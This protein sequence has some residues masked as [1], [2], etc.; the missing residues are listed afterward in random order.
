[1]PV[2]PVASAELVDPS[3]LEVELTQHQDLNAVFAALTAADIHVVSM[4]NKVNRL[5][6]LFMR[7]VGQEETTGS[8]A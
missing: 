7:L 8:A 2:L 1:V 6:E 4:R 3:T 5:E